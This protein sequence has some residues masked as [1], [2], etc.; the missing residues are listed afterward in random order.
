MG[1]AIRTLRR[2]PG[3]ALV[4]IFT[5][6]LGIGANTAIFSVVHG[7]LLRPMEFR[8]PDGIV[9]LVTK[10]Q[11]TG[12]VTPRMTGGDL[13]DVRE[14]PALEAV[15]LYFGGEMGVQLR[16]SAEFTG[17]VFV[18]PEFFSIF[19]LAPAHGRF[20]TQDEHGRAAVV[21]ASFARRHF[22][23]AP[24]AIGR[25]I[26][27]EMMPREIVGVVDEFRFPRQSEIW[28]CAPRRA[29][30][31]NRSS[32]N[33]SVV[34]RLKSGMGET[35]QALDAVSA[36]LATE[37]P[38]TNRDKKFQAVSLREQLTGPV[39]TMLAFL[40]GSVALVLLAAC[41][42][43][44]NLLLAR[45][46]GRAREIAV[47]SALGADRRRLVRQMLVETSVLGLI[48]GVCGV[49]LAWISL[50]ALLALAPNLPRMQEVRISQPVLWFTLAVS[51]LSSILF[52]L[53]PAL[54]GTRGNIV[55][56]LKQAGARGS[57]GAP[58]RQLRR[59]LVIVE[60]ALA[61]LLSYAA[62]ALFRSMM[63]LHDAEL[64]YRAD[65]VLVMYAHAPAR[66]LKEYVGVTRMFDSLYA[67]LQ[68]LPGVQRA[69][70][71]M[72][73]PTGQYS[74]NGGY[75]VEGVHRGV[76][77]EEMPQAG[78]R[79]ASPNY[80]STMGIPLLRGRD[81]DNRDQ[82]SS[83]FVAIISQTLARQS[84]ARKDPIGKRIRC[85]LDSPQWMTV[86]GVVGDV[87]QASPAAKPDAELYMPLAQHPYHANEQ[88][89]VLR[90]SVHPSALAEVVRAKVREMH[91]SMAVKL[92]TMQ[93]MVD[94]SIAV[95]RFRATLTGLFAGMALLLVLAGVYGV[96]SCLAQER[97]VEAGLRMAL[98]ASPV[99]ILRMMLA[100]SAS[101]A[102][103]GAAIGVLLCF[104]ARRL[105]ESQ[106]AGLTS[107][108]PL[109]YVFALA[110]VFA[111]TL[112]AAF[113]PAWRAARTDPARALA[114]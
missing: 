110:A 12:R 44:A 107:A 50:D 11:D 14:S 66:E 8:D 69:A 17:V 36:R 27:V 102:V 68:D 51:L 46:P 40:L 109:A 48:G 105:L 10:F 20:F 62:G 16:D 47:R 82:Y 15:S 91:P 18:N 6:A 9:Q 26:S 49:F 21:S 89:V 56:A 54:A 31:A 76:E 33:Y 37:F 88:Q 94:N 71:A 45:M 53:T 114:Q 86:I 41:A 64:G 93:S 108:P 59:A 104:F 90:T 80:F 38:A 55:D 98:G 77:G 2:N 42:N 7:V 25:S 106:M 83:P 63:A 57:I 101:L 67:A 92:V 87:R 103:A 61:V 113:A 5:L 60:I 43:V 22:G 24:E 73:L 65:H 30:N 84:F 13:T 52:G 1:G 4:A 99:D 79:L 95:P 97:R 75:A 78:F 111:V 72:G 58:K 34:A 28:I 70:G 85:G 19:R 23:S 100:E 35:Q 96:M 39:R 74:S 29:A 3:F 32:F 81:F 112:L